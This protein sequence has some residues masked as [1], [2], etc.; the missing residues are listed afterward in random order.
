LWSYSSIAFRYGLVDADGVRFGRI[1]HLALI[2]HITHSLGYDADEESL[3][4]PSRSWKAP[5]ISVWIPVGGG[6]KCTLQDRSIGFHPSSR[7]G[8]FGI[9]ALY[10]SREPMA[11]L[12]LC[13][14]HGV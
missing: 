10:G 11:C 4:T 13:D 2:S 14:A 12:L 9:D 3:P 5:T 7:F 1:G 8:Q 6:G